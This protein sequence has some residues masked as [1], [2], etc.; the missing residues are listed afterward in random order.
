[1]AMGLL[2]TYDVLSTLS[3]CRGWAR[4]RCTVRYRKSGLGWWCVVDTTILHSVCEHQLPIRRLTGW[5]RV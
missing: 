2:V 4:L 5:P 3:T 1:M